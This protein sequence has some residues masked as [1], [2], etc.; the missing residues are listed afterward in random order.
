MD[1]RSEV[2]E[3]YSAYR[4]AYDLAK[5]YRDEVVPLRKRISEE[6]LLRYNGMLISVFELLAD[7]LADGAALADPVG[8]ALP[9]GVLAP[10]GVADSLGLGDSLGV[11]PA[12]GPVTAIEPIIA[13]RHSADNAMRC[14]GVLIMCSSPGVVRWRVMGDGP[15]SPSHPVRSPGGKARGK[16]SPRV[17]AP[18]RPRNQRLNHRSMPSGSGRLLSTATSSP[19]SFQNAPTGRPSPGKGPVPKSIGGS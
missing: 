10:L 1:A 14:V 13:V 8:A 19:R 11:A 7:A 6:N 17:Q 18:D 16:L 2:R 9:V 4:T 3:T 5:H 15:S 12:A